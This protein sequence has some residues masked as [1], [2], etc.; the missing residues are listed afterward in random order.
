[1]IT[2]IPAEDW[3]VYKRDKCKCRYCDLDGFGNFDVWIN[4]PIDHIIPKSRGG[5]KTAENK[6]VTCY[7]CYKLKDDY[8]PAGNNREERIADARRYVQEKREY[9][10]RKFEEMMSELRDG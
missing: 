4:L 2:Y 8:V 7:E 3:T 10:R 5:D 9:W 1:M 6:A